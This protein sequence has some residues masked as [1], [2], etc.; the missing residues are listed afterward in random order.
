MLRRG[1]A[2]LLLVS[3]CTLASAGEGATAEVSLGNGVFEPPLLRVE[4][5]TTVTWTNDDGRAH[6]VTSSWDDGNTFH[7]ILRPGESFSWTFEEAGTWDVH[8]V[9]HVTG[10]GGHYEGMVMTLEV[11]AA[12]ANDP[13]PP[14]VR[15]DRSLLIVG[16]GAILFLAGLYFAVQRWSATRSPPTRLR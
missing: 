9:P 10:G 16:I 8:C 11:A 4:P 14:P 2:F 5:G 12:T 15:T 3:G 7:K 1:L 6:T 13:A